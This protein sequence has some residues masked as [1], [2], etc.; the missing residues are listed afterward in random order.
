MESVDSGS[1]GLDAPSVR[2][3]VAAVLAYRRT[4]AWIVLLTPALVVG[5]TVVGSRTFTSEASVLPQGRRPT[6]NLATLAQQLGAGLPSGSDATQLPAFYTDL[7]RSRVILTDVVRASYIEPV[8]GA[9]MPLVDVWHVA[10]GRDPTWRQEVLVRELQIGLD[11]TSSPRTGVVR[12]AIATNSAA[13]SHA[14]I[15]TLVQSVARF[16]RSLRQAQVSPERRFV[17]GRVEAV[18]HELTDREDALETFDRNNRVTQSAELQT[19]RAR[20][21]RDVALLSQ[22]YTGL[23]QS[24]EQAKLEEVRDTPSFLVIEPPSEPVLPNARRTL[25]KGILG[26]ALGVL[27]AFGVVT[28]RARGAPPNPSHAHLA[29]LVDATVTDL[30]RPWRL[31]RSPAGEGQKE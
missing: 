20:L 30:S 19:R 1:L 24:L 3:L 15:D 10:P 16:N 22:V 23:V 31:F 5:A 11:V 12:V 28:W 6:G 18:K 9:A 8:T 21:Q 17:E 4:F 7:F 25:F 13:L 14:I 2:A 29:G 26:L 27:L